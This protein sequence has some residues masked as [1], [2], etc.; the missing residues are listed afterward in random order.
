MRNHDIPMM[1]LVQS[2]EY[3]S[4]M[5]DMIYN[6]L[7]MRYIIYTIYTYAYTICICIYNI[8]DSGARI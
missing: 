5:P 4:D 8:F 3:V 6:E 7:F 1:M 2:S